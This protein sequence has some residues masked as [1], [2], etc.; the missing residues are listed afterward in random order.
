MVAVIAVVVIVVIIA[1]V[2]H[3]CDVSATQTALQTY[4]NDVSSLIA[5]SDGTSGRLFTV[6]KG[7][8]AS[9]SPTNVQDQINQILGSANK[10]VSQAK[11]LSVP[12]QVRSGNGFVVQTLQM[13]AD[14]IA[15]IAAN[16]QPALSG[17]NQD[18]ITALAGEMARFYASDVV[19]KDYAAPA[20]ARA[21]NGAGVHFAGLN[22]GQFLPDVQ[23]VLPNYISG[24][25]HVSGSTSGKAAPGKHDLALNSVS[26]NGTT[27]QPNIDN[28]VPVAPAPTFTLHFT[29]QGGDNESS[30]VCKVTVTGPDIS[31]QTTVP[32][33]VAGQQ[34]TCNVTLSSS[35]SPS[36]QTVVATVEKV[37]GEKDVTNNTLQFPVQFH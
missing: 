36:I 34:S 19:Y 29:N 35:P 1:L 7:A 27:M 30:V 33:V 16:I 2:V 10:L 26:V 8:G 20:I 18:A 11:S 9:G 22:S 17:S 37:A 13:R 3:G 25:L 5:Q 12:D 4:T 14:G 15:G 21:V 32:L 31:G 24:Q 23:W 28:S 6:L